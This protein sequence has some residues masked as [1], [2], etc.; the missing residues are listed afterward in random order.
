MSGI[1]YHSH[2]D[3]HQRAAVLQRQPSAIEPDTDPLS[4]AVALGAT[5][6]V[7]GTR[8]QLAETIRRRAAG[9]AR[10]MVI[11]LEDAVADDNLDAAL[12]AT[13]VAL[14][15][16][17]AEPVAAQLFVRVRTG[18]QLRQLGDSAAFAATCTGVVIPKFRPADTAMLECA[19]QLRGRF[20]PCYVMPVLETPEV[21]HHETRHA[22]LDRIAGVLD[23]Y[24]D[25]VLALRIGAT[26]MSG[27]FAIRRSQDHTI[28]D[29]RVIADVIAAII[30]RLGRSDG[31]GF[32]ITGPVWEYFPHA[33]RLLRAQLRRA[34]WNTAELLHT[35]SAI[36]EAELDGLVREVLL[37]QVNGI[38]GKSVI[39]PSHVGIVNALLVVPA[40][41]YADAYAIAG[42]ARAETWHLGGATASQYGNKM[43]ESKPHGT[44]A[45]QTLRRADIFGVA[46]DHIGVPEIIQTLGAFV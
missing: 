45:V 42:G 41:A 12:A 6:Y 43:N 30:N 21:V 31:S 20:G 39:H 16:L 29:V 28:Y 17:A 23:E 7:P 26:D 13:R 2:I 8:P 4:L 38:V 19:A 32:P 9:G 27:A 15:E 44:W 1:C 18:E 25:G 34:P 46:K 40:E 14:E 36:L 3:P 24:R 22:E 37:D 5:L 11:D 35:R 33:E 10:S